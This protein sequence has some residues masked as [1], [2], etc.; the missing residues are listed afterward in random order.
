MKKQTLA[1]AL[2]LGLACS[3]TA[4]AQKAAGTLTLQPKFGITFSN[5]TDADAYI[6]NFPTTIGHTTE[7]V[8]ESKTKTGFVFGMEAEYQISKIFS[9]SGGALFYHAR[10]YIRQTGIQWH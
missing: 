7:I 4:I 3:N 5:L 6:P 10:M 2:L 9:V 8:L 1:A